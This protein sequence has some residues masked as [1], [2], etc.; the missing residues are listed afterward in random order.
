MIFGERDGERDPAKTPD[1][2]AVDPTRVTEQPALTTSSGRSWLIIGGI[3]SAIVLALLVS[4]LPLH[5][6]VAAITGIVAVAVLY[7]GMIVVRFALRPGRLRLRL[8]ASLLLAIAFVS[9]L[10]V[11]IVTAT[12]W[13]AVAA[14]I[15]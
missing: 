8:L 13:Y 9:L 11:G 5:A 1:P 4:M 2:A 3:F 12:E 15:A 7:A 10:C 14:P 6:P